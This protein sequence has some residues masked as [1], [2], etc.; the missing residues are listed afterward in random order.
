M[1][2]ND[3]L[4]LRDMGFSASATLSYADDG[5]GGGTL[6]VSDGVKSVQLHLLGTYDATHFTLA[7]DGQGG[8]SILG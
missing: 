5:T 8:V 6:T 3:Q 7:A 2:G 1:D 4:D